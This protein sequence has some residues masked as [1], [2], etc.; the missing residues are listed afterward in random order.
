MTDENPD[1]AVLR[2]FL[3]RLLT[4]EAAIRNQLRSDRLG[5]TLRVAVNE[6]D[7]Y[8]YNYNRQ[9]ETTQEQNEQYYI[10]S[11]GVPRLISLMFGIHPDFAVPTITLR[12]QGELS[13][14]VLEIAA[15]LGFIEHGRRNAE[16]V[17]IGR[18]R[19][20]RSTNGRYEF[21]LPSSLLDEAAHERDIETHFQRETRRLRQELLESDQGRRIA[22]SVG[23]LLEENVFVFAEHFMG[24]DAHPVLDEYYFQLAW[25]ELKETPGFDSFNELRT[26]GSI[27]FL[28]YLLGAAYLNSLCLKH[29]AFSR[30]MKKKHPSIGLEDILTI[31]ADRAEFVSTMRDALNLFGLDFKHYTMTS[32]EEAWQIYNVLAATRRNSD[33]FNRPFAPLPCLIEFSDWSVIKFLSG[34]HRQMEFLLDSLR[35]SFPREYDGNQRFREGS[36]QRALEHLLSHSFPDLEFRQNVHLRQNGRTLTDVDLV[37]IDQRFGDLFLFQIKFQDRPGPDFRAVASR[38]NRFR[39]E[40]VRWLAAVD[41]WLADADTALLKS[42]FRIPRDVPVTRKRKL[43]LARHHAWPLSSVELDEDTAYASWDQLINAV[44]LM[45]KQQGDFRTLNGLFGMLRKHI[46]SAVSRHHEDEDPSNSFSTV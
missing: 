3:D 27:R 35:H 17:Q 46:V 43:I 15:H 14:Q 26:F 18:S 22:A 24:Y 11:L 2:E 38:A 34:R 23:S 8:H 28:K 45:E 40:T 30:A 1:R 4:E 37:V 36:M 20:I 10:L 41:L 5:L 33:L 9:S 7:W 21:V 12:R 29:E 6:L 32:M 31:T 19:M 25:A 13:R 44:L 42:A 16:T 39:E